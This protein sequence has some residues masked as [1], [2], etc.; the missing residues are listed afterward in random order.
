MLFN[1]FGYLLFFPAVCIIFY[2]IPAKIRLKFLL[3][4]S[5]F[6]YMNWEPLYAIL[7]LLST[8]I[9]YLC[10]T[11]ID[12]VTEAKTRKT[13]LWI[14]IVLNFAILFLFKY[15]NFLSESVFNLLSYFGLRVKFPEFK[16]LLPVGISFYT[17]QAV[18]YSIDVY[19]KRLKHEAQFGKYALFVS[20]FPQLVAGPIERAP[21]LLPQFNK[22]I[23]FNYSTR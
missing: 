5:Y 1:S 20:F 2:L 6:F 11:Q 17:F 18:G 19:Y 7:I 15:Y 4:A 14:S 12:K 16:L 10:A 8:S 3:I 22:E 13:L 23:K 9:T 21:N